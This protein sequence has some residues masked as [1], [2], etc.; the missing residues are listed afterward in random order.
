MLWVFKPPNRFFLRNAC[1]PYTI[2]TFF[3]TRQAFDIP[4]KHFLRTAARAALSPPPWRK[5]GGT[6]EKKPLFFSCL[7][8]KARPRRSWTAAEKLVWQQSQKNSLGLG[9]SHM[10]RD[11]PASINGV[12]DSTRSFY[13]FQRLSKPHEPDQMSIAQTACEKMAYLD[14]RALDR[15]SRLRGRKWRSESKLSRQRSGGT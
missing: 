3:K 12:V 1:T 5:R 14:L 2:A 10:M 15:C 7:R 6:Q 4:P 8:F 9:K 11:A 13:C